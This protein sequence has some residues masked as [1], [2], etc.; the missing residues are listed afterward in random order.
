MTVVRSVKHPGR[1]LHDIVH[2]R[3][4]ASRWN[5]EMRRSDGWWHVIPDRPLLRRQ[6]WKLHL[7]ATPLSAPVVLDRTVDILLERNLCFKFA[8]DIERVMELTARSCDRGSGGKFLTVYPDCDDPTLREL[9]AELHM[10]TQGL[11]GPSILSDRQ[12]CSDSLV[13][14]RFGAFRGTWALG[15]DGDY[16]AFLTDPDGNL[17]KDQ[18]KAWFET[19]KWVTKCPF[20]D[21]EPASKPNDGVL[22]NSRYKVSKVIRHSFAGGVYEANDMITESSVIVKQARP[23][24]SATLSGH[25]SCTF[26]RHEA[27]MLDV[28]VSSEVTPRLIEFFEQQ[29]D[30]FLVQERIDGETLQQWIERQHLASAYPFDLKTAQKTAARLIRL[31]AKVHAA[32]FVL[33]DLKPSNIMVTD[34]GQLKLIDLELLRRPGQ[35]CENALSEGYCSPEQRASQWYSPALPFSSDA[36]SVGAVLY[37]I[38]TGA[39]PL[40]HND[41]GGSARSQGMKISAALDHMSAG[42]PV[43]SYLAP[44][45]AKLVRANP[46]ERPSLTQAEKY[47]I[48]TC[49][50]EGIQSAKVR[51]AVTVGRLIADCT[52]HL[53]STM[54]PDDSRHLWSPGRIGAD[55]DPLN[56]QRGCAG[57]MEVLARTVTALDDTSASRLR[58]A[59]DWLLG[60]LQNEPRLFP[61][62][63][64]GRSG[65]AWALLTASEVLKDSE[66]ADFACDLLTRIPLTSLNPDISHGLAGIGLAMLR[67]WEVTG[68]STFL[69]RARQV[70]DKLATTAERTDQGIVWR[71]PKEHT[72][73]Q[74]SGATYYGFAHGVAG[75]GTFFLAAARICRSDRYFEL[76]DDAANTL[77]DAADVRGG[78]A[79]WPTSWQSS[80]PEIFWCNGSAGVGSFLARLWQDSKDERHAELACG[81]GVAVHRVRWRVG[82]GQ[83]HGLAGNG[84]LLLDLAE[85]FHEPR[86]LRWAHDLADVISLRATKM[87]NL[88]LPIDDKSG[89]PHAEFGEGIAGVLAYLLRLDKGGSGM[90]LPQSLSPS[91]KKTPC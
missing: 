67:F 51:P 85:I 42:N 17:V 64:F 84:D 22:L 9:A 14:Y 62:L 24:T 13:Y 20:G 83:C 65:T 43:V 55:A 41:L 6:G 79:F 63:H 27:S 48:D 59:S 50:L 39:H 45:I 28:L 61:G 47:V 53:L 10:A 8:S 21:P 25:D 38:A 73:S 66:L 3:L 31:V 2:P 86:Y 80:T 70:A 29:G 35:M 4:N 44:L 40:F 52:D 37:F 81:A 78:A 32:G 19:P 87:D 15:P 12:Y 76:A 91:Y 30:L 34:D 33:R 36:Y 74:F 69:Q 57:V 49:S 1:M 82:L 23:Y 89:I 5:W 58:A 26:L 88:T 54:R 11:R 7:S 46:E 16:E 56:V 71:V 90:W 77:C 60:Q 72:P 75:I 18:R 68:R